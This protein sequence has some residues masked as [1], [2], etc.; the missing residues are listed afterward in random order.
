MR[1]L[2]IADF[3]DHVGATY[4]VQAGEAS[5]A[6]TLDRVEELRR[7]VREAGSFR[8]EFLGPAEPLLPQ[9]IYPVARDEEA[10][11]M[12]IVPIAREAGGI[13]YEAVFN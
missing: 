11:E 9:A 12:F 2:A 8:L 5:L 1:D 13:R 6:L 7:S 4:R 3:S 10:V